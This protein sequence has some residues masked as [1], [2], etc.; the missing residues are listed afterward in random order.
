MA[1]ESWTEIE[2]TYD[3]DFSTMLPTLVG[4]DG[5][6]RVGQPVQLDLEAVYFDTADFDLARRGVTVR[7]RTNGPDEGWHLKLPAADDARTEIRRPLGRATRTVP[8]ALLEPVRA[9]VRDRRL[10]PVARIATRRLES[11]LLDADG[12][13]LA[14]IC[15]DHVRSEQLHVG[16]EVREWREWEVELASGDETLLDL[17]EELLHDAG[18]QRAPASSKLARTL[19]HLVEPAPSPKRKK[20]LRRATAGAAVTEG[21]RREVERL[22]ERDRRVRAE[23]TGSVHKL[24]IAARRL[25]SALKTYGPLLDEPAAADSLGEELRWLGQ[26]LGPAR[27]AEVLRRRLHELVAAQPPDLVLGPVAASIDDDLRAA[28]RDARKRTLTA[29][30]DARYFRLLDHLDDLVRSPS[31]TAEGDEPARKVFAR[32]LQRDARRLRRAV[33][34]VRRSEDGEHRDAALHD[35]RKKAK[36]LRYAAESMAPVL[37]KQADVLAGSV[38]R[39][40]QTLGEFQDSVMSRRVLRDYGAR[41]HVAGQN[42]F[43]YGRLHMLEEANAEAAVRDFEDAWRQ[44]SLKGL[45]RRLEP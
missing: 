37:G 7:R 12:A 9:V 18:A 21:L 15:D 3:V 2:R 40:Q 14:R 24:R 17:V 32:L 44:L 45:R 16:A 19:A 22:L 42:G 36:R 38:K 39:I 4:I 26:E 6:A 11:A 30:G 1:T 10:L 35:A 8:D 34:E 31:F 43:T 25:R 28:Q 33:K 29:L 27:D 41:A 23:D 5:V 13:V 20:E